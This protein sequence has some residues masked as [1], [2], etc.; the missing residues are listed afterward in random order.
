MVSCVVVDDDPDIVDLFCELLEMSN[1]EIL[2]KGQD[3]LEAVELY[4]KFQ[5]DVIFTDLSMPK[6]DGIYAIKNIRSIHPHAKIIVLTGDSSDDQSHLLNTLKVDFILH[7]PFNMRTIRESITIA[8]L[9]SS[10]QT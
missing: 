10:V 3:G 9:K 1:V 7:K 5:P 2:A 4:D 8:L 6:H